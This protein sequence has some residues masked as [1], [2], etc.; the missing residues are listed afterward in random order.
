MKFSLKTLRAAALATAVAALAA[1]GGGQ[2]VSEFGAARVLAFGDETSVI[3]AAGRKY[4]VNAVAADGG[5]N[6]IANPIWV[7]VLATSFNQVFREC[8]GL[9]ADASG[10]ILAVPGARVADLATQVDDFTAQ[11]AFG[12]TD[13]VTVLVGQNDIFA[14]YATYDGTNGDALVAA[15]EA[16][17]PGVVAQVARI[18]NAGARVILAT[19]PD[20]GLTPFATAEGAE[21]AALLTRMSRRF[22]IA[23]L[24]ALSNRGLNDG[25][26]IGLVRTDDLTRQIVPLASQNGYTNT[27]DAACLPSTPL[28]D[29]TTATL[30]TDAAGTPADGNAYLWADDT[31]LAPRGHVSLG[32]VAVTRARNNPFAVTRPQDAE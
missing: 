7:Q 4:T 10:R 16:A 28:P 23:L 18:V 32:S 25:H 17:A 8:P 15:A 6:C 20:L 24:L 11:Q 21:R 30:G 31:H 22:N 14:L 27:R 2:R 9:F 5:I 13:L 1:C 12:S 19:L 29:C 3:D 26:L